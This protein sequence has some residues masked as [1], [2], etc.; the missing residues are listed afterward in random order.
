[1]TNCRPTC[2]K[3]GVGHIEQLDHVGHVELIEVIE[4]VDWIDEINKIDETWR[5][6]HG[7]A[8]R[9]PRGRHTDQFARNKR[10]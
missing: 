6:I 7:L 8:A 4:L 2:P 9:V 1:M 5:R 10:P 3:G